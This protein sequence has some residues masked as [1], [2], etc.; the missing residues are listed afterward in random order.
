MGLDAQYRSLVIAGALAAG[1]AGTPPAAACRL[2]LVLAMDVSSSVD[3]REDA[4]QR[5]GLAA[6]LIAPEVQAAFFSAP[7]PVALA[8]F[9]WSGRDNQRLLIDWRLV[10]TPDDLVAI[11]QAIGRSVRQSDDYP[12]AMGYALGYASGLLARAPACLTATV[13]MAGDGKNNEGFPPPSAY[14]AFDYGE[15][16]VNGLVIDDGSVPDIIDYYRTQVLH[17]PGAFLE[18]AHGFADYE[19]A[20][21]RKLVRE[22]SAL[23]IG[24]AR[25]TGPRG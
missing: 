8:M 19:T 9:E 18:R 12:T 7:E 15:V 1:L 6:A 22:L 21:R 25:E 17:G 2:A 10:A 23:A 13:D 16:T 5:R 3:A 11:A 24:S 4:L 20:M 14:R